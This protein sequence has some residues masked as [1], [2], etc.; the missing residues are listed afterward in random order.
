MQDTMSGLA[1]LM[2]TV[3]PSDVGVPLETSMA[4]D[5]IPINTTSKF[6]A[7]LKLKPQV[8]SAK[9]N[10]KIED[11]PHKIVQNFEQMHQPFE[12]KKDEQRIK[13]AK[14]ETFIEQEE[15][16]KI[17]LTGANHNKSCELC[18]EPIQV[19]RE[20]KAN[21]SMQITVKATI[22]DKK[23]RLVLGSPI[24][25]YAS[26]EAIP[27]IYDTQTNINGEAIFIFT[28]FHQEN[29]QVEIEIDKVKYNL[30]IN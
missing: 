22:I 29:T 23:G 1:E 9:N 8:T 14:K 15:K 2:T 16:S 18:L 25:F 17:E 28:T 5:E 24:I 12:G 4:Q 7:P 11:K 30:A 20:Q 10:Q 3:S 6:S 27:S 13:G 21:G 26:G 19:V